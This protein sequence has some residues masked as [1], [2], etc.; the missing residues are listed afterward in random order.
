MSI[1]RVKPNHN[2]GPPRSFL[3]ES[4]T[5]KN[6]P[7]SQGIARLKQAQVACTDMTTTLD[8]KLNRLLSRQE[9]DYINCFKYFV[10]KKEGEMVKLNEKLKRVEALAK[11]NESNKIKKLEAYSEAKQK[12]T[13]FLSDLCKDSN[14]E[15]IK[16]KSK[17]MN[18][19]NDSNFLEK[20]LRVVTKELKMTK[21]FILKVDESLGNITKSLSTLNEIKELSLRVKKFNE[22]KD[23]EQCD[24]FFWEL[25]NDQPTT[26]NESVSKIS[27]VERET[28]RAKK[29]INSLSIEKKQVNKSAQIELSQEISN[30]DKSLV[31]TQ[32]KKLIKKQHSQITD[33]TNQLVANKLI[34]NSLEKTFLACV[35][36]T[37]LEIYKRKIR[38]LQH[39]PKKHSKSEI[40]SNQISLANFT[41]MDKENVL[42]LFVD[43][44]EVVQAIYD[45][46]FP[47][48]VP[49]YF[50][51][52][53]VPDDDKESYTVEKECSLQRVKAREKKKL[54]LP[55]L[56][57]AVESAKDE[58]K[59]RLNSSMNMNTKRAFNE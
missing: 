5:E 14:K 44:E 25:L 16:W 57:Q 22:I 32:L 42:R 49:E 28:K 3:T 8:E 24:E 21:A 59:Q 30:R 4:M 31:I 46:M 40:R 10:M 29:R 53:D 47:S 43:N 6:S 35:E 27:G 13:L 7:K 51:A 50:S 18:L 26:N 34:H 58:F 41:A 54:G 36:Q 45:L 11:K 37:R 2:T 23:F 55:R 15:L 38:A 9:Q 19:L 1:Q 17:A 12:E 39:L 52:K 56:R 20:K 48:K 33:L